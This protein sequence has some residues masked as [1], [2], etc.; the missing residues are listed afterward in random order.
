MAQ[1]S[2][3]DL[4]LVLLGLIAWVVAVALAVVLPTTEA[5][6]VAGAGKIAVRSPN[7]AAAGAAG[8]FA[9]AGSICFLGAAFAARGS[10]GTPVPT[11]RRPPPEPRHDPS[12]PGCRRIDRVA[13]RRPGRGQAGPADAVPGVMGVHRAGRQETGPRRQAGRGQDRR[14][15]DGR[16]RGRA[17]PTW[18]SWAGPR[19]SSRST[20]TGARST[21]SA[22]SSPCRAFQGQPVGSRTATP[23][24]ASLVRPARRHLPR[25]RPRNR[26]RPAC[27]QRRR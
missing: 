21:S 1:R 7:I 19:G 15:Q 23:G 27:R 2:T 18:P 22:A 5:D 13:R 24:P 16:D 8:G 20:Q 4:S 12:D 9:V 10:D 17:C 11:G 6:A 25:L 3:T 14:V 26:G